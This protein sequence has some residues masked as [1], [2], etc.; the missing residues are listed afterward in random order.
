[1]RNAPMERAAFTKGMQERTVRGLTVS[2]SAAFGNAATRVEAY[3]TSSGM[4]AYGDYPD[5]DGL[6]REQIG[7]A[8]RKRREATLHKVQQLVHETVMFYPIMEPAFLNGY[9]ARV[10]EAGLGLITGYAY[11]GP[12]ARPQAQG[13]VRTPA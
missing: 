13:Q 7:E 5:I 10:A 6:A 3:I 4:Y 12:Y 9:G 11:S 1:M 8:D 2:G